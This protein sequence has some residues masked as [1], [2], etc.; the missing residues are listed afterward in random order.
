MFP[1]SSM[2]SPKAK[3]A[4]TLAFPE[5][6]WAWPTEN[7][8][9]KDNANANNIVESKEKFIFSVSIFYEY[10]DKLK[11]RNIRRQKKTGIY[12]YT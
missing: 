9:T 1:V 8:Q 2:E 4:E 10:L 11:R 5:S 12:T 3:S 6:S 7:K